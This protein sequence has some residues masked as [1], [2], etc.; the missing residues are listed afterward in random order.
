[1]HQ[2]ED[3]SSVSN[4]TKKN[5]NQELKTLFKGSNEELFK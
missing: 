3:L 2:S 4:L 5:K 1:M